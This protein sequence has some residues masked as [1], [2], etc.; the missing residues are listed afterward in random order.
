MCVYVCVNE[1][2]ERSIR[3]LSTPIH[4]EE[5]CAC[6]LVCWRVCS[7]VPLQGCLAHFACR[8]LNWW[9]ACTTSE[10]QAGNVEAAALM[11]CRLGVASGGRLGVR[12]GISGR[13]R[14]RLGQISEQSSPTVLRRA[15]KRRCAR[16]CT[17]EGRSRL[18]HSMCA[19]HVF[20]FFTMI[21]RLAGA[22]SVQWRARAG[23]AKCSLTKSRVTDAGGVAMRGTRCGGT[24]NG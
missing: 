23:T 19:T 2:G 4:N 15:R 7:T 12:H 1:R 24:T 6:S 5:V 17:Q 14:R 9:R 13:G 10:N 16:A 11:A 21:A 18:W 3:A 22:K 8:W 20:A